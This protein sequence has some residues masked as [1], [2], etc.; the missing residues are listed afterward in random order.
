MPKA[1]VPK[2]RQTSL[3]LSRLNSCDTAARGEGQ[4]QVGWGVFFFGL[5]APTRSQC[6][7]MSAIVPLAKFSLLGCLAK[8][9]PPTAFQ[10]CWDTV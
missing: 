3:C 7:K 9:K 4:A 10:G 1:L 6:V 2:A 5:L 8:S